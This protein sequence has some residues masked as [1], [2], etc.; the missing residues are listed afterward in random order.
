M[1][2]A[3][4]KGDFC[5][6]SVN[7]PMPTRKRLARQAGELDLPMGELVRRYLDAGLNADE[8]GQGSL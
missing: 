8:S 6:F 4:R 7:I 5:I 2:V 1:A 3:T